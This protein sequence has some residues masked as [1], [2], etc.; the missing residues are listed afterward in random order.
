MV[1]HVLQSLVMAK[2]TPFVINHAV[3]CWLHPWF[4]LIR[5]PL[6]Y[7]MAHHC[8]RHSYFRH[9]LSQGGYMART[10]AFAALTKSALTCALLTTRA[11]R[12]ISGR[13]LS[14]TTGV[15][16][17]I[18]VTWTGDAVLFLLRSASHCL[19]SANCHKSFML[20]S[21]FSFQY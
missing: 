7:I 8:W 6:K 17:G 3:H 1:H 20:A 21:L 16:F 4:K 11:D 9:S 19:M 13:S 14:S 5:H 12:L 15:T 2:R 10:F 18:N